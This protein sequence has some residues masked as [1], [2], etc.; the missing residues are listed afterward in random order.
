MRYYANSVT[1]IKVFVTL[2]LQWKAVTY[3]LLQDF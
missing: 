3:A 1:S 2:T